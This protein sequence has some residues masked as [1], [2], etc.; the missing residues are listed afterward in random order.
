MIQKSFNDIVNNIKNNIH[1]ALPDVDTK[2]GTFIRDV[3]I[4]PPADQLAS[5]Y[6]ELKLIDLSQSILTATGS[7]L[8]RLAKNYFV[9]R[10]E[11]TKSSGKI[12]FYIKNTNVP[13]LNMD[14]LPN[15]IFI[16]RGTVVATVASF[17]KEQVKFR[18]LDSYYTVKGSIENL[19]YDE[20]EGYRYIELPIECLEVGSIGNINPGEINQ[21]LTEIRDYISHVS[22]PFTLAGGTDGESDTDLAFRMQLAVSGVN[23]GTKNGYLSYVLKQPN[24]IDAKIV[25]A[26]DEMMYRDGGYLTISNSYIPGDGGMVDIYVRGEQNEEFEEE[27]TIRQDFHIQGGVYK[28]ITLSN[29]PVNNIVSIT[30]GSEDQLVYYINA[31]DFEIE[32]AVEEVNEKYYLDHLWDFGLTSSFPDLDY[33][34]NPSQHEE[35]I[36]SMKKEIDDELRQI[37]THM[38]NVHSSIMWDDD[39]FTIDEETSSFFTKYIYN[40]DG[41]LYK[42]V[43]KDEKYYGRSFVRKSDNIYVRY[44]GRPDYM[45]Y[46]EVE[47]L[48]GR[49]VKREYEEDKGLEVTS[50]YSCYANSIE[51]KDKIKW[52]SSGLNKPKANDVL[53]IKY[54]CDELVKNL[55]YGLE[56]S[57]VLTAD[58]LVK[59][60]QKLP[61][62]VLLDATCY[63]QYDPSKIKYAISNRV[64]TYIN[65]I[66]KLGGEFDVSDIVSIA[67]QTEGVDSVDLNTIKIYVMD[68]DNHPRI[69][70]T[71]RSNQY[72]EVSNIIVNVRHND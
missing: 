54:N 4:N 66:K 38:S 39:N 25:G 3:F 60:T 28:D 42:I 36:A 61:I 67:R 19:P 35:E 24:I 26:G 21:Q 69:K 52:L 65:N 53:T 17:S 23:I 44:Y 55:Q 70:V 27:V 50:N 8:D 13:I 20:I 9:T 57:K 14:S 41:R 43:A 72:F 15:E 32:R 18:T 71:A 46:K 22:N 33:Y 11:A 37:F 16:S 40:E 45:L 56:D 59:K 12:R 5:L 68:G 51:A 48:T 29:Q 2:S 10:K 47:P 64:V 6:G 1:D 34:P 30:S 49:E 7:D 63:N 31:N 58:V 62:E